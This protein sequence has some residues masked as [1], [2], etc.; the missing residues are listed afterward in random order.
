MVASLVLG[1]IFGA[2]GLVLNMPLF[3]LRGAGTGVLNLLVAVTIIV[4]ACFV[5]KHGK[6]SGLIRIFAGAY[7]CIFGIIFIA[8]FSGSNLIPVGYIDL[9]VGLLTIL[10]SIL[11]WRYVKKTAVPTPTTFYC[12]RCGSP[13]QQG[14]AFCIKCGTPAAP[15]VA[16]PNPAMMPAKANTNRVAIGIISGAVALILAIVFAVVSITGLGKWVYEGGTALNDVELTFRDDGIMVY[17]QGAYTSTMHY[18][19]T[20]ESKSMIKGYVIVPGDWSQ[21]TNF[22]MYLYEGTLEMDAVSHE[23]G[24]DS[25]DWAGTIQFYRQ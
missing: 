15:H 4:S 2:L 21:V 23:R 18:T 22:E 3:Q 19:I 9:V 11:G 1:I 24:E 12:A 20:Y 17:K 13:I 6:G 14:N 10:S 16:S 25:A 7:F 5:K 8:S